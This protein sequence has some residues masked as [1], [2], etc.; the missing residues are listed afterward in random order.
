MRVG[1]HPH[2][3]LTLMPRVLRLHRPLLGM[4]AGA[5]DV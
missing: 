5:F 2:A 4:A 1:S 3:E